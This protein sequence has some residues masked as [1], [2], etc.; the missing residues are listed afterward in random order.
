MVINDRIIREA[1]RERIAS[2]HSG[3]NVK[4]FEELG[5]HYGSSRIDIAVI[6]NGILHGYEI[7]SDKDNLE[8][9]TDQVSA[10]NDVFD[11]LT[12]VVGK[13][14]IHKANYMIPD[15]WGL[16]LAKELDGNIVLHEIRR[17][18]ENTGQLPESIA[19]LVWRNEALDILCAMNKH[20][21]VLTKTRDIIHNRMAN[22]MSLEELKAI[23]IK[24]LLSRR[25]WRT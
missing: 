13:S 14:H 25:N 3:D 2:V 18:Q 12:L 7:K 22:V 15:W 21:G 9:L 4:V 16:L 10:Y 6:D 20:H 23:V 5:L 19:K 1:L 8:R 24:T 17:G 11:R